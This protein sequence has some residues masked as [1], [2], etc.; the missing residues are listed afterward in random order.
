[1]GM[2]A[3]HTMRQSVAQNMV[4]AALLQLSPSLYHCLHSPEAV[5]GPSMPASALLQNLV[6]SLPSARKVISHDHSFGRA[7]CSLILQTSATLSWSTNRIACICLVNVE[8][9]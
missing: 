2:H 5:T 6:R 3:L 1:M 7:S 4:S 9:Q 8:L